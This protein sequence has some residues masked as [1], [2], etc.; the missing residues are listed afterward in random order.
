M[1]VKGTTTMNTTDTKHII[2]TD[3]TDPETEG[4]EEN[5]WEG[6]N[7]HLQE[8]MQDEEINLNKPVDGV[9]VGFAVLGLWN[10]HPNGGKVYGDNAKSILD[11]GEDYNEWYGD[12]KD[13][14]GTFTHHDGTNCVLFRIAESREE[15]ESLVE[16]IAYG[17]MTEEEFCKATKS[18]YP[19]VANIYGWE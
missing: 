16:Q 1:G 6:L 2:Y 19:V 8:W 17:G 14:R 13:I 9:I 18:L 5:D 4:L 7:F 10:G 11:Y 3:N 12:G 15:A